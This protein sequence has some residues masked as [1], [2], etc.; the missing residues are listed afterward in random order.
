MLVLPASVPNFLEESTQPSPNGVA[1]FPRWRPTSL[2]MRTGAPPPGL[3]RRPSSHAR[4]VCLARIV[5]ELENAMLRAIP[6]GASADIDVEDLPEVFRNPKAGSAERAP[7]RQ[8]LPILQPFFERTLDVTEVTE[9][10]GPKRA[11]VA[12]S[13][14][15]SIIQEATVHLEHAPK[16]AEQTTLATE[17]GRE[18][19]KEETD[20]TQPPTVPLQQATF[21]FI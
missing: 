3:R 14:A 21:M 11:S 8:R 2:N 1:T 4:H 19:P 20:P 16:P 10:R 7:M 13:F 17:K 6:I 9:W 12:F 18:H 15:P 5:R